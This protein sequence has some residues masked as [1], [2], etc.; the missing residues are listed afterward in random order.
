MK[1]ILPLLFGAALL[2]LVANAQSYS[3]VV[4][5]TS[6]GNLSNPGVT[7][8]LPTGTD[9]VVSIPL[10]N[11]T[12]AVATVASVAGNVINLD[13][14]PGYTADEWVGYYA[15]LT[16]G[17]NEG[18]IVLVTTNDA[19]TLTVSAQPGDSLTGIAAGDTLALSKA[20]TLDSFLP[21][22]GL[23]DGTFFLTFDGGTGINLSATKQYY[24]FG[25]SWNDFDTF[26]PANPIL[27]P[28]ESYVMR[29]ETGTAIMSLVV[30]GEVSTAKHR[31]VIYGGAAQQD[32]RLAYI[33][34]VSEPLDVTSFP[35]VDG[36]FVLFFDNTATG[37]NKSAVKQYY[38]FSGVW[39]DFDTFLP[40]SPMVNLDGGVG[41][42]YRTAAAA[43]DVIWTDEQ[44]YYGTL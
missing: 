40:P 28:G 11:P 12:E 33:G 35:A 23:P 3:N 31:T 27:Y 38:S 30:S 25:G 17:T 37:I 7:P 22:A 18:Q 1:N 10:L 14:T 8:A 44:T 15:Q 43:G 24:T 4:G 2:P 39:Y 19:S 21:N 6:L 34:P 42:V 36:D 20:W 26:L 13:G 32:T 41:Y 16:S 29:N 5:Y 9:I